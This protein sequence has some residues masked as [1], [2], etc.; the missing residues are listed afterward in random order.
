MKKF[1]KK[2]WV[3]IIIILAIVVLT[4]IPNTPLNKGYKI[5]QML[6]DVRIEGQWSWKA[7]FA[8]YE[9]DFCKV[10]AYFRDNFSEN[11]SDEKSRLFSFHRDEDKTLH[12]YEIGNSVEEIEVPEEIK[13]SVLIL[14]SEGFTNDNDSFSQIR[15]FKNKI[16]FGGEKM[17]YGLVY[18]PKK[19]PKWLG[20]PEH[21]EVNV[22]KIKK[23]WYHIFRK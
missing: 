4:C 22:K 18:S 9:N 17:N 2:H 11:T 13:R 1:L 6:N 12:V 20:I 7:N 5:L 10:Q 23:G 16:E 8:E 15:V 14:E 19:R 21:K 3:A